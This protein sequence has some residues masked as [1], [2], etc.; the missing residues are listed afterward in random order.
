[1]SN[2]KCKKLCAFFDEKHLFSQLLANKD[3]KFVTLGGNHTRLA[4][5]WNL[6]KHPKQP[7]FRTK[8]SVIV[9]LFESEVD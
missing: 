2:K 5:L 7:A 6:K 1:M 9:L 3:L 4:M 8:E